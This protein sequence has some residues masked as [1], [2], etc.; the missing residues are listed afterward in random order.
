MLGRIPA[1]AFEPSNQDH[2]PPEVSNF[3]GYWVASLSL[4]DGTHVTL[5]APTEEQ[6][7]LTLA[8][9]MDSQ[10]SISV[11][12]GNDPILMVDGLIA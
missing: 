6:V 4:P 9:F 3:S 8:R 11:G 10:P 2:A 1:S 5:T 7:R 12:L